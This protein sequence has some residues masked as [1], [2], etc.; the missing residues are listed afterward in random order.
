MVICPADKVKIAT[1]RYP[2]N[3]SWS[4]D[5][6]GLRGDGDPEDP[7]GSSTA[8]GTSYWGHLSFAINE[9]I[10]GVEVEGNTG[11]ACWHSVKF[12]GGWFEC[13]GQFN[14]PNATGCNASGYRLRGVLDRVYRPG[15]VGLVFEAGRDS[16][17]TGTAAYA[18]LIT[19]A[20]ADGP[21]LGDSLHNI[22]GSGRVPQKRHPGGR[23]NVLFA[24]LHGEPVRPVEFDPDDGAPR[25]FAPRVRVSPYPPHGVVD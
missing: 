20:E 19:S 22:V 8:A 11:P 12:N 5:N 6:N 1:P 17:D 3:S 25:K 7:D 18:N 14:Y 15:D 24:D 21:Y 9:D 10:A 23:V 4:S 13:K 16:V 2:W